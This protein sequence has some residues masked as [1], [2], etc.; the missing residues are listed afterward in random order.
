MSTRRQ[1]YVY[2]LCNRSRTLYIGV[3]NN[4]ARRVREHKGHE[5]SGFTAKYHVSQLVHFEVFQTARDAITREKQ[6]KS[7]RRVKKVKLISRENPTW[8]DL[9]ADKGFFDPLGR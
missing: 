7:W 5:G 2:I 8:R 6:L 3:T 4:L 9:S 1:F